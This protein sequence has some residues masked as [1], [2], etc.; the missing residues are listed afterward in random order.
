MR[1]TAAMTQSLIT[2]LASTINESTSGNPSHPNRLAPVAPPRPPPTPRP[3]N[4]LPPPPRKRYKNS[5]KEK[6][7][8]FRVVENVSFEERRRLTSDEILFESQVTLRSSWKE[9]DIRKELAVVMKVLLP[10]IEGGIF[11]IMYTL[12]FNPCL[13]M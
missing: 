8:V 2:S 3:M 1:N 5:I 6:V 9:K 12:H 11:Y 10:K 7:I 4:P 13:R